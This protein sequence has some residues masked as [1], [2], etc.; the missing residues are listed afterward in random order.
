MKEEPLR[1]LIVE[2]DS[3]AGELAERALARGRPPGFSVERCPTL[4]EGVER[5]ARRR[6][7]VLVLDLD[8]PDSSGIR[9]FLQAQSAAPEVPIVILTSGNGEPAALEA[10]QKGAQDYVAKGA[11]DA[12]TLPRALRYAVERKRAELR[13]GRLKEEFLHNVSHELKT[14]LFAFEHA[15]Q[16]VLSGNA[17]EIAD[18]LR[19]ILEIADRN[20]RHLGTMIDDL[21]DVT[22]AETGKLAVEP[23]RISLG[24]LIA[25]VIET[26]R[27]AVADKD[28]SLQ[29]EAADIPPVYADA[30]RVRQV[31]INLIDNAVKFT[32]KKGRVTVGARLREDAPD[33]VAVSVSDTGCGIPPEAAQDVFER[34]YQVRGPHGEGYRKGLGIGLYICKQIVERHGG[35]IWVESELGK[36][37]TFRFT[38]P[39]FSLEKLLA[40][41]LRRGEGAA[42]LVLL[43]VQ[44]RPP[45]RTLGEEAL[46]NAVAETR[47][48]LRRSVYPGDIVLPDMGAGQDEGLVFVAAAIDPALVSNMARRLEAALAGAYALRMRHLAPRIVHEVVGLPDPQAAS[49]EQRLAA[50]VRSIEE[51]AAKRAA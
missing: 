44:V 12:Q 24:E 16:L 51:I 31:L 42:G 49:P 36:G 32:S 47:D 5:I 33:A 2:G 35:R 21:L 6:P 4:A 20:A 3:E 41:L 9:T 17:G 14:P 29:A 38:L 15:V 39:V 28:M 19:K 1:V 46:E 13:E 11:A 45:G 37:S 50:A 48:V 30:V 40:P 43:R 18:P 7:D 10:I 23:A 8:L 26:E 27:V 25:D 22:R 34:L